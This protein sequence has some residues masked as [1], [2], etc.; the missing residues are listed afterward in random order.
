MSFA[1]REDA[2]LGEVSIPFISFDDLLAD[3]AANA[4]PKDIEDIKQL[5]ARRTPDEQ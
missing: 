2:A 4:R 1:N 5:K 3:K